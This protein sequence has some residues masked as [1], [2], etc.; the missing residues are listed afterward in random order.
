MD[1]DYEAWLKINHSES[2]RPN[3]THQTINDPLPF[4][5]TSSPLSHSPS[6]ASSNT[7]ATIHRSPQRSS[8][9]FTV[10]LLT[11]QSPTV[12]SNSRHGSAQQSPIAELFNVPVNGKSKKKVTTG[13]ACVLTSVECLK[14]LQDKENE[15]T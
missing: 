4:V 11:H 12:T 3:I 8:V 5:D 1:G 9:D 10:S 2:N 7:S 14:V 15:K 6:V 13:K